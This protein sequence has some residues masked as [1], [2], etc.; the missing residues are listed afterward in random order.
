MRTASCW[1]PRRRPDSRDPFPDLDR[2]RW[3]E[4][5][6]CIRLEF[7]STC[8]VSRLGARAAPRGR[9]VCGHVAGRCGSRAV[10]RRGLLG[11][12]RLRVR[13]R[14]RLWTSPSRSDGAIPGLPGVRP[15]RHGERPGDPIGRHLAGRG[16]VDRT[17]LW[18]GPRTVAARPQG[19]PAGHRQV[20]F[21]RLPALAT[22]SAW[23]AAC[24]SAA[25]AGR[26]VLRAAPGR[27]ENR[28]TTPELHGSALGVR[29]WDRRRRRRRSLRRWFSRRGSLP[30]QPVGRGRAMSRVH[31]GMPPAADAR[32]AAAGPL[33]AVRQRAFRRVDP[34]CR[35]VQPVAPGR[36]RRGHG[37]EHDGVTV[38][39]GR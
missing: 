29:R 20:S 18:R 8:R 24:G 13:A 3:N 1:R 38:P 10:E 30:W 35:R 32:R 19:Q 21:R 17:R 23:T 9:G 26:R 6:R 11:T 28:P 34:A 15:Y 14:L 31:G 5:R 33:L 27:A 2:S 7:R 39:H 37:A 25:G 16:G 12:A 22:R 4:S 36:R